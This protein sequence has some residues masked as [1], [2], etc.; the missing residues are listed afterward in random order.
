MQALLAAPLFVLCEVLFELGYRP[1][2]HKRIKARAHQNI[3]AFR[4]AKIRK[5]AGKT[6]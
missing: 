1:K 2:L 6:N 4:A 3:G 5:D